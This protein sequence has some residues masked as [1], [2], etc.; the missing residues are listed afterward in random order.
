MGGAGKQ[1]LDQ[2]GHQHAVLL[3]LDP[4]HAEGELAGMQSPRQGDQRPLVSPHHADPKVVYEPEVGDHGEGHQQQR[5]RHYPTARQL[6]M[7]LRLN[8]FRGSG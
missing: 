8:R 7:G 2:I 3:V 4:E 1:E 6:S 5:S